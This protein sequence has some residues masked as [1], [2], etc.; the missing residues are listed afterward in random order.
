MTSS[1]TRNAGP[2]RRNRWAK[3]MVKPGKDDGVRI[4][5]CKP[6][7]LALSSDTRA[8][9]S[10]CSASSACARQESTQ[11]ASAPSRACSS[12]SCSA[13]G[14]PGAGPHRLLGILE[15]Q[16]CPRGTPQG[17]ARI[18]RREKALIG[19][20]VGGDRLLVAPDRGRPSA[21]AA[22]SPTPSS[23]GPRPRR[24]A[25][26]RIGAT[27]GGVELT[28]LRED[29]PSRASTGTATWPSGR[30]MGRR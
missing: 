17:G 27:E 29:R 1:K 7:P 24:S 21:P 19:P 4:T 13:A 3:A 28:G 20:P 5:G 12:A 14:R 30:A 9:S 2:C 16:R 15:R 6:Q 11:A 8:S 26:R 22:A 10:R 18:A 25:A 23:G